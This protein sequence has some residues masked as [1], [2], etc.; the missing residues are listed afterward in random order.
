MPGGGIYERVD[1]DSANIYCG[2]SIGAWGSCL[3]PLT[4]EVSACEVN[5]ALFCTMLVDF[6]DLSWGP[7][8]TNHQSK[9]GIGRRRYKKR[10]DYPNGYVSPCV[11]GCFGARAQLHWWKIKGDHPYNWPPSLN[12][13]DGNPTPG[14]PSSWV[15]S[16][17]EA[18]GFRSGRPFVFF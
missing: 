6:G 13:N 17:T 4:Y 12:C 3:P 5:L 7:K 18:G 2:S 11:G 8:W 1:I 16:P 14:F 9:K 15:R 10:I